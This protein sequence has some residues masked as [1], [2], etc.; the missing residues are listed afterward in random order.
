MM[1]FYGWKVRAEY[2]SVKNFILNEIFFFFFLYDLNEILV[3][4][5]LS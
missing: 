1:L 4:K 3:T 2:Y 5:L